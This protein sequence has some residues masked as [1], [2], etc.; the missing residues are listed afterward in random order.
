MHEQYDVKKL[1]FR[2]AFGISTTNA[3]LDQV[4]HN[5]ALDFDNQYMRKFIALNPKEA[6]TR[7]V[8]GGNVLLATKVDGEGTYVYFDAET[9]SFSFSAGGRVRVGYPALN[10]MHERLKGL[11]HKKALLRCELCLPHQSGA[12]LGVSEVIR[13]SFSGTDAELASL[14]LLL[15]DIV[16]LDGKDLRA[17]QNDFAAQYELMKQLAPA[18]DKAAFASMQ[19]NI[20]SEKEVM[21]SFATLINAGHEGIVLRRL[22]RAETWKI[23]PHRSIDAVVIG[24][25]EGEFEEQYGVNS[26][27]TAVLLPGSDVWLQSFARVGSGI[28]DEMRVKLLEQLRQLKVDAPVAMTDSSGREI[29]FIKPSLVAELHGEDLQYSDAG[30]EIK[31][32]IFSW[33]KSAQK[34]QF[35]GMGPCPK[36][37]FPRFAGFRED[38]DWTSGGVRSEQLGIQARPTPSTASAGGEAKVIRREVYTKG[39]ILRKLVVVHKPGSDSFPYLIYWTDYSA[40]RAEALKISL[41]VASDELRM[42][43][44]VNQLKAENLPKGYTQVA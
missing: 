14:R 22:N 32:Q 8:D 10:A 34:Y 13:I 7:L 38:K 37:T 43:A 39:E 29:H 2:G 6:A 1:Q 25:V 11:G 18:D 27:L 17:N 4:L 20:V 9:G 3:M 5:V 42:E 28:S 31:S 36:L 35:L 40:K 24:F 26:L 33:D 19:A 15:L 16:M 23:K 21:S 12:R 41:D 44:L 30:K